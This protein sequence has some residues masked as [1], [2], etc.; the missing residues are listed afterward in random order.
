MGWVRPAATAPTDDRTRANFPVPARCAIHVGLQGG[1]QSSR[2]LFD[3]GHVVSVDVHPEN[4]T[5]PGLGGP[6]RRSIQPG[7]PNQQHSAPTAG[8]GHQRQGLSRR[9]CQ[10][11]AGHSGD[12]QG[13]ST[14]CRCA[15]RPVNSCRPLAADEGFAR[16]ARPLSAGGG[17]HLFAEHKPLPRRRTAPTGGALSSGLMYTSGPS[18]FRCDRHCA[19]STVLSTDAVLPGRG[20]SGFRPT[21]VGPW[22][23]A[24]RHSVGLEAVRS[25]PRS[26]GKRPRGRAVGEGGTGGR[27]GEFPRGRER[28]AT[29]LPRMASRCAPRT[30][31]DTGRWLAPGQHSTQ[32]TP[33]TAPRA[34]HGDPHYS[35]L[36][37]RRSSRSQ[38]YPMGTA[39][40]QAELSLTGTGCLRISFGGSG[41]AG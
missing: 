20:Q 36:A 14:R 37:T 10:F 15:G 25:R 41:E 38:R 13:P 29:P 35:G 17:L 4:M 23:H 3:V 7:I 31:R 33:P 22:R 21:I 16:L 27:D 6:R 40:G 11:G 2:L 34:H 39:F 12:E 30:M 24:R 26:T 9:H 1:L 32:G 19:R 5:P 8:A 28:P 18:L